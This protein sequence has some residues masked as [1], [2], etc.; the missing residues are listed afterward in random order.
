[1]RIN[2][3]NPRLQLSGSEIDQILAIA[4]AIRVLPQPK[5]LDGLHL[6]GWLLSGVSKQRKRTRA[7]KNVEIIGVNAWG[8]IRTLIVRASVHGRRRELTIGGRNAIL[9]DVALNS[10][11]L[12]SELKAE[13]L[14]KYLFGT[15]ARINVD[16]MELR[17]AN[18]E[19]QRDYG[20]LLRVLEDMLIEASAPAGR[21]SPL[22][23]SKSQVKMRLL[24]HRLSLLPLYW[25]QGTKHS[26]AVRRL[27]KSV[28]E[29]ARREE[30]NPLFRMY[31]CEAAWFWKELLAAF[32]HLQ[33]DVASALLICRRDADINVRLAA[34]I[35]SARLG[36]KKRLGVDL[37][38]VF[39][40]SHRYEAPHVEAIRRTSIELLHKN[41]R[42]FA[43]GEFRTIDLMHQLTADSIGVRERSK[44]LVEHLE[45]KILKAPSRLRGGLLTEFVRALV[46]ASG[47]F[48]KVAG[49]R[50]Q[51]VGQRTDI[52]A[53]FDPTSLSP[54]DHSPLR[55]FPPG[56]PIIFECKNYTSEVTDKQVGDLI[57]YCNRVS[58]E[59]GWNFSVGVLVAP[60]GINQAGLT[61]LAEESAPPACVYHFLGRQRLREMCSKPASIGDW[62]G[63]PSVIR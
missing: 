44:A 34:M 46:S 4:S 31:V 5:I 54:D 15:T 29:S 33:R 21:L 23:L 27:V 47:L 8:Y 6:D 13:E 63:R 3:A 51:G 9:E 14:R 7:F 62:L 16:D 37:C 41:R 42:L 57:A 17:L 19:L 18:A 39:S 50:P 28:C 24:S 32:P 36:L 30:F 12:S 55:Q 20:E 61:R 2:S 11:S 26:T 52:F 48:S 56:L 25:K 1:M 49:E 35:S 10:F 59:D 22:D 45:Q 40:S 58:R 53:R 60:G 38:N 43:A